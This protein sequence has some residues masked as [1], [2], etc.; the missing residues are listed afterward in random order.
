MVK[1]LTHKVT[2]GALAIALVLSISI[3]GVGTAAAARPSG[4]GGGGHTS[5]TT[6]LGYDI[7]YPQCGSSLPSGQA[8]GI[9]GVNGGTAAK[10]NGCLADQLT[11]AYASTGAVATQ[12]K[13]Q[14]YVNTA[15]PGEVQNQMTSPWPSSNDG[16]VTNPYGICANSANDQAC[17]WEYGWARARD[18]A[19]WTADAAAQAGVSGNVSSYVWWLDVETGNTWEQTAPNAYENNVASLEGETAYFTNYGGRVGLYSTASQWSSITGGAV[20]TSS[21]LNGLDNWRPGGA[22]LKTAKQACTADP[23]TANG[24]VVLTQFVAKNLDNDYSCI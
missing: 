13:V 9:V 1:T 18:A 3:S 11:W 4:G 21:N 16:T 15:N 19:N 8:F 24:R 6:T 10:V 14:L 22:N 7:S 23:L 2:R 5:G 17:S 12:D 20:S